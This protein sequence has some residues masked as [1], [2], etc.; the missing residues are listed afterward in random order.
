MS[1]RTEVRAAICGLAAADMKPGKIAETLKVARSTVHRVLKKKKK[2]KSLEYNMS[3]RKKK[4]TPTVAAGL[5]RR[6]KAAPTKSLRQVAAES[7]QNRELVRRLVMIS[8][9]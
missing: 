1:N 2:G 9:W 5:R 8:G 3:T 6:I 4:L 7:G